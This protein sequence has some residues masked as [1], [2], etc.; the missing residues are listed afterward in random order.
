MRNIAI[1]FVLTLVLSMVCMTMYYQNVLEDTLS[2]AQEEISALKKENKTKVAEIARIEGVVES[3][4]QELESNNDLIFD[5][6]N[7]IEKLNGRIGNLEEEL[8]KYNNLRQL[9]VVATA[10]QA[11][12]NTGCIGITATGHDVSNTV[13]KNGHRVVAVDPNVIPLG[14]LLHVEAEDR[15]FVGIAEDTGGAIKGRKIDVLVKNTSRAVTFG[16]QSATI[17]VLREGRS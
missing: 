10:Y 16:K 14:S 2:V 1:T 17:T 5:L 9:D 7:Q 12:C 8:S 11:F 3:Q 13:Y 6:N 4:N 15:S